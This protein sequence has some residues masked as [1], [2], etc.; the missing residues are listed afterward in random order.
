[1]SIALMSYLAKCIRYHRKKG[2]LT[3]AQLAQYVGVGE[4]V[5]FDI[6]HG[7][8]SIQLNTLLRVLSMLNIHIHFDSPLMKDFKEKNDERNRIFPD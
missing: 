1:M 3:Q 7:K 4:T 6:E 5:I 8:V 2:E